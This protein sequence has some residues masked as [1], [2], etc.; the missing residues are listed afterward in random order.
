MSNSTFARLSKIGVNIKDFF[1]VT[2]D[3]QSSDENELGLYTL[4]SDEPNRLKLLQSRLAES[5]AK[6][7]ILFT[8]CNIELNLNRIGICKLAEKNQILS[9]LIDHFYPPR[10]NISL[11]GITGTNGKTSVAYLLYQLLNKQGASTVYV[12]TLGVINAKNKIKKINNTMPGYLE[13]R[14]TIHMNHDSNIFVLELTSIGLEQN[15]IGDLDID[16]GVWTNF[17]QDHLDYHLTMENYFES[18]KKIFHHLKDS[19]KVLLLSS[20]VN[21]VNELNAFEHKLSLIDSSDYEEVLL[22]SP[23]RSGFMR[24]NLILALAALREIIGLK[25]IKALD[26][27]ALNQPPGRFQL[28]AAKNCTFVIDY[29]HTPDALENLLIAARKE[30]KSKKIIL[31]F[32]CGGNRDKTKRAIMGGI[33]EKYC[34]EL[35]VTSDNPRFEDPLSIIQDILHGVKAQSKAKVIPERSLAIDQAY[36]MAQI[37]PSV[38][39]IAGKGHEIGQ[40]VMG[41]IIPYSDYEYVQSHFQSK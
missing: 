30:F 37:A 22:N 36:K 6:K 23:F 3:I 34:D 24:E 20:Q 17:T 2:E 35:V 39:V 11:V 9:D 29:A 27:N 12:G 4:H 10:S 5:K 41:E 16:L 18:K 1:G 32:G 15:R 31:V 26:M 21:L 28:L 25:N 8:D 7:I 19:A 40:E 38:V 13:L 14:K 33:A